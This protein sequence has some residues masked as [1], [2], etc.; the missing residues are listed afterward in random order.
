MFFGEM[1]DGSDEEDVVEETIKWV[2]E[3]MKATSK[4]ILR[5]VN[6]RERKWW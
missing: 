4:R 3:W 6:D 5:T 1:Y 2:Q